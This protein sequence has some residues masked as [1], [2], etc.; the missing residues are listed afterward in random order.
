MDK[1]HLSK[2]KRWLIERGQHINFGSVTF[3]TR[4]GEPD[5]MRSLRSVRTLKIAGGDNGPRPEI[6]IT[7]FELR[8]EQ[9]ALLTRLATLSDGTCVKVKF[10]H[11]LPGASID[12]EEEHKAA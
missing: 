10:A 8:H 7:D 1:R 12:I 2:P 3:Y 5:L 9:I 6:A 4:G 11:G